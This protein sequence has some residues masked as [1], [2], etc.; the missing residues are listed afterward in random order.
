M[1]DDLAHYYQPTGQLAMVGED[2]TS[3]RDRKAQAKRESARKRAG[4]ACAKKLRDAADALSA[5]LRA[6]N[7]CRDGSG[8]ERRG[9]ADGRNQQIA[10]LSEYACFLENKYDR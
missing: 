1:S 10:N 2:W 6:C 3:D 4:L 8:D 5:Y 9:I 7:E